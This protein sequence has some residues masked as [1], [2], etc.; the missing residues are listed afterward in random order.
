MSKR[1]RPVDGLSTVYKATNKINGDCYIGIT[2]GYL[3]RRMSGHRQCAENFGSQTHFHRAIRKYGWSSFEFS[4]L[5]KCSDYEDAKKEEIRLISEMSPR[6]NMTI[7][8]DGTTGFKMPPEIVSRLAK[9]KIGSKG[10]WKGKKLPP[11]VV[12]LIRER[13]RNRKDKERVL[14]LGPKSQQR[15]II[16]LD[17]GLVFESI[18][19]ASAYYG[20]EQ[21]Q[22]SAVCKKSNR[23]VTAGGKV[24]RYLGDKNFGKEEAESAKAA[25]R[26]RR[27]KPGQPRPWRRGIVCH[28]KPV[29][30]TVHGTKH[31]SVKDA[32]AHY[33][34]SMATAIKSCKGQ[35][36]RPDLDCYRFAYAENSEAT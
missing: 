34:I 31:A 24:F 8:G 4:I 17:D 3:S 12:E 7:G 9:Q 23:R 15:K 2:S 26:I 32:A 20:A 35:Y 16:C 21:S 19:A 33:G 14:A 1:N 6:Y 28:A 5:S 10:Y 27:F 11:H 25:S 13:G 22:I 36:K 18:K 29:I 30:C